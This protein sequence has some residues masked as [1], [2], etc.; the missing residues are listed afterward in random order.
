MRVDHVQVPLINRYVDW[1][2]NRSA[3]V[4]E[5]RQLIGKF[6]YIFEVM[7]RRIPTALIEVGNK[8]RTVIGGED[9]AVSTNL[10]R[11]ARV[12]G[13]LRK[14]RGSGALDQRTTKASWK[15][16]EITID[17]GASRAPHL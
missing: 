13:M 9:C 7:E 14:Y 6:H 11:P 2:D 3:A 10:N 15:F 12:S 4:M 17:L 5:M 8:R 1:L 16:Y